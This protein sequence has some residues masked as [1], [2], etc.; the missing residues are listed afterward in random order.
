[1]HI[2]L[3]YRVLV[4]LLFLTP[5]NPALKYASNTVSSDSRIKFQAFV[6]EISCC[7]KVSSVLRFKCVLPISSY[8]ISEDLLRFAN[9]NLVQYINICDVII[10]HLIIY[11]LV[12][13]YNWLYWFS[14]KLENNIDYIYMIIYIY[15]LFWLLYKSL[16]IIYYTI[17]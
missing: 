15:I 5:R 12:S 4:Y 3:D 16:Y 17:L 1:M 9:C 2:L 10:W 6:V 11:I 7:N 8:R 13:K 14:F